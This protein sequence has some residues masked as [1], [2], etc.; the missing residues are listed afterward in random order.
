V[1]MVYHNF[2]LSNI[3]DTKKQVD[4]LWSI[5]ASSECVKGLFKQDLETTY[6]GQVVI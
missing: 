5:T 3:Y 4:Q 2:G 1:V 6:T